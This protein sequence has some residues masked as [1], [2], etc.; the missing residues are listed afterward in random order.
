[1]QV[2]TIDLKNPS[3]EEPPKRARELP[4]TLQEL[5]AAIPAYCF[6][7]STTKSL[8][9]LFLDVAIVAG[10]Y[11]IAH[12]LDSWFFWPVFWLMQGTMFWALF[13]VGHDCGHRS[14]SRHKW[15][16]DFIGHLEQGKVMGTRCTECGKL[17]FPPRADCCQCMPGA[18][19]WFE[20]SGSGKLVSYSRLK[21]GPVGFENDLPY[22]IALLDYGDYKVFGRLAD[23]L[24]ED[25]IKVGMPMKTR[26]NELPNG[27]LNYVFEP[28]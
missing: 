5:K 10:L 3:P 24:A 22:C 14:F 15:V 18:M 8:S 21:F 2:D 9:Y 28:A 1:M 12:A 16:N 20:V 11:A 27:Q 7:P 4:F 6:E 17:F 25:Q 23:G 13:V 26:V 19:E